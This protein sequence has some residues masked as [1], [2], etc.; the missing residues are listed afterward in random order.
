MI[1]GHQHND[2][3]VKVAR[4][5]SP[6]LGMKSLICKLSESIEAVPHQPFWEV[7]FRHVGEGARR[8]DSFG[9]DFGS[10]TGNQECG[11]YCFSNVPRALIQ[12]SRPLGF[13][14]NHQIF[15]QDQELF[16]QQDDQPL[17]G[18]SSCSSHLGFSPETRPFSTTFQGQRVHLSTQRLHQT[19]LS[20]LNHA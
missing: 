6:S 1:T 14:A 20:R 12:R 15:G 3:P 13:W 17:L 16:G 7:A 5:R 19:P 2:V 8:W 9:S 11:S 10:V 18:Q 4:I